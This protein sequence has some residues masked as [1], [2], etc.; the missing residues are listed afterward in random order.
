M[1]LQVPKTV[2]MSFLSSFTILVFFLLNLKQ[3]YCLDKF[4]LKMGYV[5][6]SGTAVVMGL[7]LCPVRNMVGVWPNKYMDLEISK[8]R[9]IIL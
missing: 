8:V 9:Y 3:R 1:I 5:L 6:I 2:N 4:Y 7:I